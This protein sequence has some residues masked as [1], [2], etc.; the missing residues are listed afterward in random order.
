MTTYSVWAA[1][2]EEAWKDHDTQEPKILGGPTH[3][4]RLSPRVSTGLL[5]LK[6]APETPKSSCSKRQVSDL[7]KV[8]QLVS[9]SIGLV[10][11]EQETQEAEPLRD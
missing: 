1:I 5:D 6:G 11:T 3:G 10:R 2:Q 9:D 7:P 8:T 4:P